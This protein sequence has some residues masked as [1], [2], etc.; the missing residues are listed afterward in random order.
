MKRLLAILLLLAFPALAQP[1]TPFPAFVTGQNPTSLPLGASDLVPVIQGG[2]TTK[3]ARPFTSINGTTCYLTDSCTVAISPGSIALADTHVLV[4][5][6]SNL[7]TD[8]ALSGALAITNLGVT[9]LN[10]N[11][12]TTAAIASSQVT[13][14][15]IQNE[16]TVTLLGNPTGS[17]A[18][19]SE[20]TLGSGLT[21][22]GTTLVATGSGGTVTSITCTTVTCTPS[23][24]TATGVISLA[25][26]AVTYAKIQNVATV[27]LL[28]NPTGAPAAVSEITLG[29][30]L[31]FSGTTLIA[32]GSGGTVTSVACGAGL[33]CSPSPIIGS[34]TASLDLTHT[35][36]WTGVQSMNDA[37][38]SLN[39]SSSGA[40]VLHA[41]ATGGVSMTFP[42]GTDTVAALG[43]AETFTAAQTFAEVH[44]GLPEVVTLTSN[45]YVAV[46]ADCGKI[47]TLPTGTTPTVHLPN[48]NVGCTIVFVTTAAISY[49]FLAASGGTVINSQNFTKSRGTN[50]GDTISATIVVNS[51]SAA[52]WSISGDITS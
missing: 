36:T 49:Q 19:P 29:S 21:F 31:S 45:D 30:G 4:G 47:K 10:A 46:A 42:A 12:V 50:A 13:Y 28:G 33:T 35:N 9:S 2:V 44:G 41:P 14:A 3:L 15:K 17:L 26:S 6:G 1:T 48:L 11:A 37:K 24:I 23:P 43:T 39:G 25:N 52:K 32:T 16:A 20:I 8:V 7:A 38:L 5:N 34:G 22:S 27:S 18:A 51:G 40:T